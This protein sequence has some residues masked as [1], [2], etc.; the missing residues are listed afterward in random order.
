MMEPIPPLVTP[1]QMVQDP[2][3]DLSGLAAVGLSVLL[4]VGVALWL[5]PLNPRPRSGQARGWQLLAQAGVFTSLAV[6]MLAAY[7]DMERAVAQIVGR[8]FLTDLAQIY[9]GAGL[10]HIPTLLLG[11]TMILAYSVSP[12][13]AGLPLLLADLL[14]DRFLA[15]RYGLQLAAL[16]VGELE[17]EL[18]EEQ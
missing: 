12:I 1:V 10:I 16:E 7:P 11:A 9:G 5:A 15:R 8:T 4:L 13:I 3:P 14:A 2:T 6:S 18:V 17:G